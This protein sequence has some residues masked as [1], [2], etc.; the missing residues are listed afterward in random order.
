MNEKNDILSELEQMGS[1]LANMS[2]KMPYE[3]PA[4]YFAGLAASVTEHI[5]LL[6][7]RDPV[8]N[9]SKS[10]VQD[11]P[12][13]YFNSLPDSLLQAARLSD[14]PQAMPHEVPSGYFAALPQQLFAKVN[15]SKAS[16][17]RIITLTAQIRWAAA[18][19][20]VICMGIGSYEFLHLRS[21]RPEIALSK[22]PQAKLQEYVKQNIDDFDAD[23]IVSN[24]QTTDVHN[25]PTSA[26][27]L[28][29]QEI[30]QYLDETGWDADADSKAN[31]K[32]D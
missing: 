24:L 27:Q 31:N 17:G 6:Q 15:N 26:K 30:I 13:G 29:D 23:M 2:R 11:V 32:V 4:D 7:Q 22:V 16:S 21:N 28:D 5:Q 12:A 25:V 10:P 19:L 18:A 9:I 8:L 1:M 20:L 3:V 14:M